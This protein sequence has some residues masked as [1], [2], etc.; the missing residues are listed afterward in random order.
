M[1]LYQLSFNV[2]SDLDAVHVSL[3]GFMSICTSLMWGTYFYSDTGHDFPVMILIF[4]ILIIPI[5]HNRITIIAI[6]HAHFILF[7]THLSLSHSP[8]S[9]VSFSVSPCDPIQ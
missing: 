2:N 1:P 6:M 4:E 3:Y 9:K 8:T 7:Q 5:K